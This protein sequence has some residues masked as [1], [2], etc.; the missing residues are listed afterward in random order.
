[1]SLRKYT[2]RFFVTV[3]TLGVLFGCV[4]T[5]RTSGVK[6][7]TT[8]QAV[9]EESRCGDRIGRCF[10]AQVGGHWASVIGDLG[11]F[12]ALRRLLESRGERVRDVFWVV[13]EPLSKTSALDVVIQ[14][15]SHGKAFLGSLKDSEADVT[16][17]SLD[18]Q[19]LDVVPEIM[20]S[21]NVFV[22][23]MPMLVQQ[24]TLA[25]DFLPPG[26]YALMVDYHGANNW[27]RKWIFI[28]VR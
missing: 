7:E 13:D 25:Q 15:N 9:A 26:R 17:H 10:D 16:I 24:D 12:E 20:P 19:W 27:D 18:D 3:A 8:K 1:M 28:K 22:N 6:L 23:G 11:E 21:P 2:Y 4:P 5:G 14:V